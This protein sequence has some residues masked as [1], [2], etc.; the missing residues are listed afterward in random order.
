MIEKVLEKAG[1]AVDSAEVYS[2][3]NSK[4]EVS[5]ES[6]KLKSAEE[7]RFSG[8]GLRVIHGGKIGFSSSTDPGRLDEMMEHASAASEFGKKVEF[9]FPGTADHIRVDTYDPAVETYSPAAAI[10]EG[11][12]A[13]SELRERVPK[14]MTDVRI[15]ASTSTI[16]LVNT[17][18]LDVTYDATDFTHFVTTVIIDGDSILWIGDGG[19]YGNLNIRTDDYVKKIS[20]L[21]KKAERKAPRTSGNVPVIFTAE[22]LPN[23]LRSIEMGIDGKRLLKGESPLIGREGERMLSSVTL[24]DDPFIDHAPGSRPFDAE[25]VPSQKNILFEDGVFR[26]FLFDLDTAGKTG[27]TTTA[28]A[29]RSALSIPAIGP[30]NM[31]MSPGSSSLEEM[32][33]KIDRG[34]IVYG[35]L[36]GGQSNLLAGDFALNIMLGFLI[37]KGEIIGRL[38]DTMVSGNVYNSFSSIAL[39]GSETRLVGSNMVVPDVMFSEISLSSR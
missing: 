34:V 17:A 21:A 15:S 11:K 5:F 6:G 33:G 38:L 8:M 30:S 7:K 3:E 9:N 1:R 13:V 20:D 14:G 10:D 31:A 28:S 26:S 25:G 35:V 27:R 18:G 16:R 29:E 19:H 32:I 23:L 4:V 2:F 39:T 22:E 37:Q 24:I 12:R 36:G